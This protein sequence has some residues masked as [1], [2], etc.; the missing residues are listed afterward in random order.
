MFG[1]LLWF[2][3]SLGLQDSNLMIN[4]EII[5][6]A[7]IY[8]SLDIHAENEYLDIYGNYVNEMDT[9]SNSFYFSP[10]QDYFV[11]GAKLKYDNLSMKIE[12]ECIHPVLTSSINN[13]KLYGGYTKVEV[14]ISSK[15]Q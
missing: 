8:T 10:A 1:M 15:R 11:V 13:D 2:S 14:T 7:P 6:K 3:L 5:D 4:Q 12:H 9:S